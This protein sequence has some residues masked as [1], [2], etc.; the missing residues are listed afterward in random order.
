MWTVAVSAAWLSA[1]AAL[2]RQELLTGDASGPPP[3]V[4][5]KDANIPERFVIFNQR[6]DGTR[7]PIGEAIV[8]RQI[9]SLSG[10]R[11]VDSDLK[12]D[13]LTDTAKA[14]LIVRNQ[15]RRREDGRLE[16]FETEV[17]SSELGLDAKITGSV[18]AGHCIAR[19]EVKGWSRRPSY[20]FPVD[21]TGTDFA[22][23]MQGFARLPGL[24][25]GRAWKIKMVTFESLVM[26]GLKRGL[27]ESVG[28]S[29][30]DGAEEPPVELTEAPFADYAARV[31]GAETIDWNGGRHAV[32]VVEI[33]KSGGGGQPIRLYAAVADGRVLRQELE[34]VGSRMVMERAVDP[35]AGS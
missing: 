11:I 16:G 14:S 9:Q 7:V 27:A 31:T 35:P 3:P 29:R 17:R 18:T 13:R 20:R 22:G 5:E 25:P 19:L 6:A 10:R 1:M 23:Q 28:L 26:D 24:E 12:L 2:F 4:S 15:M 21:E 8:S 32:H 30:A 33:R 34:G